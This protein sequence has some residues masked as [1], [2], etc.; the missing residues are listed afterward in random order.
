MSIKR[1]Y[2]KTVFLGPKFRVLFKDIFQIATNPSENPA[3]IL[4]CPLPLNQH[5]E[6]HSEDTQGTARVR[7]GL[8]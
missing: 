8:T 7:F 3:A 4:L 2:R 6:W 1:Q 5:K